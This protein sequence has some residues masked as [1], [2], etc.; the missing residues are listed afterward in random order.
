VGVIPGEGIGPEVVPAALGVLHAVCA[1]TGPRFEVRTLEAA[2]R[3]SAVGLSP[4]VERFCQAVFDEGGAM[5]CG[6]VGGRFVYDLRARFDLY[7]KLVPIRP[8]PALSDAMIV[9]G[10]RTSDVDVL[11]VRENVGGLYGGTF[12]RRDDGRVAFQECAYDAGQVAR[13]VTVAAALAQR[14]RGRL[15]VVVKRGG[16]PEVSALWTEQAEPIARERAVALEILDVDNAGFQLVADPRRFDVMV[17]P[18][19][20]GD[21][22]ADVGAVLLGSR[23]MSYSANFGP[24]RRAVYQTGHGAAYDLAGTDRANPV[25]QILALATMLRESFR[26]LHAADLVD[27]AVERVLATGVR[28]PDVAGPGTRVVGTRALGERIAG[29]IAERSPLGAAVS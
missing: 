9:G 6:P 17:A 3:V 13:I 4:E 2:A 23:G 26:L 22:L 12:G 25:A 19:M 27:D 14:R 5:L 1:V 21:V 29:A 28:T 16:I 20:L 11:L 7:C 15:A 18:N 8:S 10:A 24:P